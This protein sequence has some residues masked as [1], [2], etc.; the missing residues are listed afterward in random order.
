M[1]EK[2]ENDAKAEASGIDFEAIEFQ[3]DQEI[4][5]L[6]VPAGQG[7]ADAEKPAKAESAVKRMPAPQAPVQIALNGN[8]AQPE[9]QKPAAGINELE[10]EINQEIDRLFNA[11]EPQGSPVEQKPD[12]LA[13]RRIDED[14]LLPEPI[15]E[16]SPEDI[17]PAPAPV[18]DKRPEPKGDELGFEIEKE[19]DSLF[20]PTDPVAFRE[21]K[22]V[23][24]D[25][26]DKAPA[27]TPMLQVTER[28]PAPAGPERT[29]PV[30]EAVPRLPAEA[31]V[32]P[33]LQLQAL[34]VPQPVEEFRAEDDGDQELAS[35][36]EAFSIAYL[37]LD[38]EFS[39][40]NIASLELA[41]SN[42]EPY[43]RKNVGTNS[44][45]KI[46][47][48]V[49]ARVKTKPHTINPQLIELVRDA[50]EAIKTML[51]KN[52]MLGP[53][54]KEKVKALIGRFQGTREKLGFLKPAPVLQ[55]SPEAPIPAVSDVRPPIV[56]PPDIPPDAVGVMADL[57]EWLESSLAV[58]T[59]AAD[60][61]EAEGR[62]LRQL[63]EILGR[64]KALEPLTARLEGIRFN[65]EQ[66][67][68]AFRAS[69]EEWNGRIS[70]VSDLERLFERPASPAGPSVVPE[71]APAVTPVDG[72]E[73]TSVGT[74]A[75][76]PEVRQEQVCFFSIGGKP[77]AMLAP[78]VVKIQKI[79]G[80]KAK[81]IAKRGYATLS[82]FK[83]AFKN[84]KTDLFGTW[85]GLPLDVLKSY[86]FLPVSPEVL[87]FPEGPSTV[88]GAVMVSSGREHAIIFCDS[89]MVDLLNDAKIH[90]G[91]SE[92]DLILGTVEGVDEADV[93]VFNLDGICGKL[94]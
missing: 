3:I 84:I 10:M 76:Q 80:K 16:L 72:G 68:S 81:S 47:S 31:R 37:S 50:Q 24:S 23:V 64:T 17:V 40:E 12:L 87:G 18:P 57:R 90:V 77:F 56:P 45:Y 22:A 28:A 34:A 74:A 20:V 33:P 86:Q 7:R 9:K 32:E 6:F 75:A 82:D 55:A 15:I 29:A 44:V 27:P 61:L 39:V 93:P 2:Q 8:P 13:T 94:G 48:M 43:C 88:G 65:L 42:L 66:R 14:S 53:Q 5:N 21:G 58:V 4:D 52:G 11:E 73:A 54:E 59:E 25:A 49:L 70:R 26:S 63:E 36:I 91:K 79:S 1:P 67:V 41:L 69:G 92:D 62:K 89:A 85:G 71:E 35:L 19:I 30:R 83:P 60:G 46:L 38:W 78:Q 51:L